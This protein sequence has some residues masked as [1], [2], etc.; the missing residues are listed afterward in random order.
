MVR[1]SCIVLLLAVSA[2]ARTYSTSFP[3]TENPLSEGSLWRNGA[4]DGRDWGD[5]K[6]SGS[7]AHGT[8][9]SGAPPFND[10]TCV[11]SGTWGSNQTVNATVKIN[12]TDGSSQQEVELRLNTTINSG[13]ITGYECDYNVKNGNAYVEIVRWNGPLNSFCYFHDGSSTCDGSPTGPAVSAVNGDVISCSHI[14]STLTLY[15][16]G[17]SQMTA[18]DS[19]YTG[20]GPGMGFWQTGG[21]TDNLTDFGLTN[22]SA[23]DGLSGFPLTVTKTGNGN[24]SSGDTHIYCGDI[25]SYSYS[26]GSQVMLSALPSSGFTFKGWTGCE[27]VNTSFCSVTMTEATTVNAAFE[28]AN[29]TLSALPLKP[30]YV[31]GGQVAAGTLTLTKAAPPGGVTVALSSDHPSVAHPP[32][33]VFVPGGRISVGFAVRTVPVKE[34]TTATIKATAG[35]SQVTG[36]LTVG[37]S[38][39]PMSVK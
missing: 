14:G 39:L 15:I 1:T 33:F 20:G 37:T 12:R 18:I 31:R 32:S 9:I 21:T 3:A 35:G 6:S 30:T 5:C 4:T 17:V 34:K 16:N 2:F 11:V 25:C 24:V 22:F 36:A 8:I 29:V 7:Q 23:S 10:P 13:N 19:T 27:N 28:V 38:F 26:D